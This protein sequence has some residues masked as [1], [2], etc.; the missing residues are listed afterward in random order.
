MKLRAAYLRVLAVIG[1]GVAAVMAGVPGGP[2]ARAATTMPA[3][4]ITVADG[5]SVIA[6]TTVTFGLNFYWNEYGT[7]NWHA[8]QVAGNA[9][10]AMSAPSVAQVGNGVDIAARGV[11]NNLDFYWQVN[12]ASGWN[13][14]VVAG[15]GTTFSTPVVVQDGNSTIIAAE[16]PRNSLDFY[17]AVNGTPTWHA[18]VVA[19]A[20]TTY[21]APALIVN[22]NSVNIAA[23]G[24]NDSL[25][26]YWAVNGSPTWNPEVVAGAGTTLSAPAMVANNGGVDIVA[27]DA[28]SPQSALL[29]F[30]WAF[31][32]NST[33]NLETIPEITTSGAAMTTYPGGVHVV[34]SNVFSMVID[35]ANPNGTTTWNQ[36]QP[37]LGQTVTAVPAVTM[38]KGSENVAY[39]DVEGDLYFSWQDS[40][41]KFH[42]EEVDSSELLT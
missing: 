22:G 26:F 21:S 34:N 27:L 42:I 29:D 28:Q 7:N 2:A 16:G 3:P 5:N 38:N 10:T 25:D 14:E 41:N 8:E 20:G 23:E 31:N 18:E 35:M 32:G 40:S 12:G 30:Y 33:W 19:G 9:T 13:P 15:P 11:T 37:S 17:W 36:R 39:I 1:L 6:A 4:S 24:P